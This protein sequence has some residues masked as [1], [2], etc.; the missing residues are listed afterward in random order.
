MTPIPL[1]SS[2]VTSNP[3]AASRQDGLAAA[4]VET[5]ASPRIQAPAADIREPTAAPRDRAPTTGT[6]SATQGQE[7][8]PD[9]RQEAYGSLQ[10]CLAGFY[11]HG[12]RDP[13][14]LA[15]A[16]IDLDTRLTKY[17][18]FGA[19]N[20]PDENAN[21][22]S[23]LAKVMADLHEPLLANQAWVASWRVLKLADCA[24]LHTAAA[25]FCPPIVMNTVAQHL[26]DEVTLRRDYLLRQLGR[27]PESEA[28]T[29][30]RA[31]LEEI[32]AC[33]LPNVPNDTRGSEF[34]D[35]LENTTHQLRELLRAAPLSFDRSGAGADGATR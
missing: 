23:R 8:P 25:R 27:P 29:E 6:P 33:M 26:I 2:P 15:Y 9:P 24:K 16:L 20:P 18:A 30:A 19:S 11:L 4:H 14:Q 28:Y 17:E 1:T 22:Q 7:L 12:G 31:F 10:S 34:N 35:L 13:V 32:S 5:A 21:I 3:D